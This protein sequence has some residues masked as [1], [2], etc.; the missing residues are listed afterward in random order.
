MDFRIVNNKH[1]SDI[2]NLTNGVHHPDAPDVVS[3]EFNNTLVLSSPSKKDLKLQNGLSPELAINS[4]C[5][6]SQSQKLKCTLTSIDSMSLKGIN[7]D[8]KSDINDSSESIISCTNLNSVNKDL[9]T[10][11]SSPVSKESSIDGS[12]NSS[13]QTGPPTPHKIQALNEAKLRLDSPLSPS[14]AINKLKLNSPRKSKSSNQISIT[15]RKLPVQNNSPISNSSESVTSTSEKSAIPVLNGALKISQKP[16]LKNTQITQ[17]FPIRRSHR[18]PKA[19]LLQEKQKEVEEKILSGKEEGLEVECFSTKGRGVK[20]TRHFRKGE[21]VVEYVGDLID[22]KEAKEREKKYSL[23]TSKGCYMY[24]FTYQNTHIDATEES[25]YLGR[26][27]NHSRNGN[28]VTK[29][30]E[31]QGKPHLILMAKKDLEEG[32]EILYDYGDRSKQSLEAH[33]WLAF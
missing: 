20:T 27:V 1:T 32:T 8:Y 28:L 12:V 10:P 9:K 7:T 19:A 29:A 21:M 18:K 5:T 33:P 17:F 30:V 11:P 3:S 22:M 31:V 23:D 25:G 4:V 2:N 26:L 13:P 14:S 24:Y 6:R 16:V 15:K